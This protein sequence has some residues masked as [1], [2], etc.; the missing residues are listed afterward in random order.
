MRRQEGVCQKA[1]LDFPMLLA[2]EIIPLSIGNNLPISYQLRDQIIYNRSRIGHTRLTHSFLIE[3]TVPPKCTN[4]NQ[5]LSVKHI[6]TELFSRG[7]D[8]VI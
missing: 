4:C 5:L 2:Q 7:E 6:L 1:V 8:I 3:H